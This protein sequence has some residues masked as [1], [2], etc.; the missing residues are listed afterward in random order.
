M[1]SVVRE[2]PFSVGWVV[3]VE[4]EGLDASH[5]SLLP[6]SPAAFMPCERA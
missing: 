2:Y 6:I 5:G 1:V 3:D 4:Q